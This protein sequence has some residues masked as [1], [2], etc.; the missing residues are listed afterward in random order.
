MCIFQSLMELH[1]RRRSVTE[2]E[3]RYFMGQVNFVENKCRFLKI[4]SHEKSCT[5]T[6]Y[7]TA[8][9]KRNSLATQKIF[10]V[11][12]AWVWALSLANERHHRTFEK[13]DWMEL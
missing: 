10:L 11:I 7:Q 9:L 12:C 4:I 13:T 6:V 5:I 2:P 1:K 8:I 3:A